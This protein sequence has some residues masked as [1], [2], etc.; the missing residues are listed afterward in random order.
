MKRVPPSTLATEC[1]SPRPKQIAAG[2]AELGPGPL[3][4]VLITC[5]ASSELFG[6]H[7]LRGSRA[8]HLDR[9]CPSDS[10]SD[11]NDI[12]FLDRAEAWVRVGLDSPWCRMW[13]WRDHVFGGG[14][15]LCEGQRATG[16]Q[17]PIAAHAAG[18]GPNIHAASGNKC[19]TAGKASP[20]CWRVPA[21]PP[22]CC[23]H[24]GL[25]TTPPQH[26][27]LHE[28]L[29]ASSNSSNIYTFVVNLMTAKA[30]SLIVLPP[31]LVAADESNRLAA[32]N[33]VAW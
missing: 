7:F 17:L 9:D 28:G 23:G 31:V 8:D 19:G 26:N 32:D 11:A 3:D 10:R 25:G 5:A 2:R 15:R 1:A 27:A 16:L 20:S 29:A 24:D 30:L 21:G 6:G 13:T 33:S 22:A 14:G 12:R 18:G 4:L